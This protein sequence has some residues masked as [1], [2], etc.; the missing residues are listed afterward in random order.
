MQG[1][2]ETNLIMSLLDRPGKP[3]RADWT[4]VYTALT[5]V[6]L[7]ANLRIIGYA[8]DLGFIAALRP[9]SDLVYFDNSY[10]ANG[11]WQWREVIARHVQFATTNTSTG[12]GRTASGRENRGGRDNRG[13]RAANRFAGRGDARG[14][15]ADGHVARASNRAARGSGR[16]AGRDGG[17]DV[18]RDSGGGHVARDGRGGRGSRVGRGSRDGRGGNILEA[19]N[20]EQSLSTRTTFSD[21]YVPVLREI[22]F[23]E[24]SNN[25]TYQT[26]IG[27][28]DYYWDA[29]LPN[30]HESIQHVREAWQ[31][32]PFLNDIRALIQTPVYINQFHQ[33]NLLLYFR[34][35][36]GSVQLGP[37]M[38]NISLYRN[39]NV[40]SEEI[41]I[42]LNFTIQLDTAIQRFI[43]SY[44]NN[45][46]RVYNN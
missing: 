12:H 34:Q 16:D 20:L 31:I 14:R 41:Q 30:L 23:S 43:H 9:P 40:N 46:T 18:G 39:G 26:A 25:F 28:L 42:I 13:G 44:R 45:G 8:N 15:S 3:S 1:Q 32:T 5:R 7:G 6:E 21:F 11:N 4:A 38:T 24:I 17:H 27:I 35:G 22:F 36:R 37:L 2:S 19:S 33:E 10:D 29:T